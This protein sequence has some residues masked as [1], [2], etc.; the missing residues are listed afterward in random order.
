M[1]QAISAAEANRAF[2]R[3]LREVREGHSY[4][5]TAHGKPVARIVPCD[6]A[7]AER[8]IARSTLLHR[9]AGQPAI[10]IGPWTRDAL[11]ER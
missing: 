3:L 1:D 2:S 10:D 6:Q 7:D 8:R 11:Y 9:L 4:V 5:V